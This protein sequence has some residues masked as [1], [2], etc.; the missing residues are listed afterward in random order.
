MSSKH[1]H[2]LLLLSSC[3][4][5]SI[6]PSISF[7]ERR[8]RG[9]GEGRRRGRGTRGRRRNRNTLP[10]ALICFPGTHW[11]M[12]QDLLLRHSKQTNKQQ[13]GRQAASSLS[14]FLGTPQHGM[15]CAPTPAYSILH[16]FLLLPHLPH[17]DFLD[18]LELGMC[19]PVWL[20]H[21]TSGQCSSL[22]TAY[23]LSVLTPLFLYAF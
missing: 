7:K 15:H 14:C 9:Q 13:A 16:Y 21:G 22:L 11:G 1:H 12:R 8:G 19:W 18:G 23:R 3:I 4:M 20:K 2:S 10:K 6:P 5:P 17:P